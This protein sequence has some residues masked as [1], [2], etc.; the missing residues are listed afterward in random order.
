MIYDFI[1]DVHGHADKLKTL[2]TRLGYRK[3]GGVYSHD[4]SGRMAVFLGD[5]IDRGPAI[6]ETLEIARFM[7]DSGNAYA[8]MGNHEYNAICFHTARPSE[9]GVWMRRRTD[10]N[11]YQYLETLYQFKDNRGELEDYLVWF[12]TLP[13]WLDLGG[14]RAV[15]AA[16]NV[17]SM[18]TLAG[19]SDGGRVIS[20]ELLRAGTVTASPEYVS[21]QKLLKGIEIELPRGVTFRDKDGNSRSKMRVRW[22]LKGEGKSYGE[23][24]FEHNEKIADDYPDPGE[25]E[26]LTGYDDDAPVFFGHYWFSGPAPSIID[27]KFAC[28]DYSVASGGFLTAYTW[29]GEKEL[30]D[31]GFTI[32]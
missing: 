7:V 29:R 14:V 10:K 32:A 3:K 19:Y 28:L 11:L 12:R 8:I 22:W 31:S 30:D 13:F 1:G 24:T 6:R 4:D 25:M 16:W 2:L 18:E 17:Q 5:F 9:P 21:L 23:L 26:K 27:S 20:E 15:H